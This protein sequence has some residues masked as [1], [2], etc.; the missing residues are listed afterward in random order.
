M[1]TQHP[2]D[3][4]THDAPGDDDHQEPQGNPLGEDAAGIDLEALARLL[5]GEDLETTNSST[6]ITHTPDGTSIEFSAQVGDQQD[7]DPNQVLARQMLAAAL[8]LLTNDSCG[9]RVQDERQETEQTD[10]EE[11]H[12]QGPGTSE[13]ETSESSNVQTKVPST[14]QE[15]EKT[16]SPTGKPV[17]E[18]SGHSEHK[19]FQDPPPK[20]FVPEPQHEMLEYACPNAGLRYNRSA[21]PQGG[22][23]DI[24]TPCNDCE[25]C[26]AYRNY[27]KVQQYALSLPSSVA[28]ILLARFPT[29]DDANTFATRKAHHYRL[30]GV[31]RFTVLHQSGTNGHDQPCWVRIIWDGPSTN[32]QR[33]GARSHARK[34][35]GTRVTAKVL[36]MS[37]DQFLEWLPNQFAIESSKPRKDGRGKRINT[38]RFSNGWV[39]P[40]AMPDDWLH[41]RTVNMP[42]HPIHEQRVGLRQEP[43]GYAIRQSWRQMFMRNPDDPEALRAVERARYINGVDWIRRWEILEP[44]KIQACRSYIDQYLS[45][46]RPSIKDWQERTLGPRGLVIETAKWLNQEREPEPAVVMVAARLGYVPEGTEPVIDVDY[47]SQLTSRLPDLE[48]QPAA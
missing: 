17:T 39:Q 41:G 1:A 4:G 14:N 43:R 11:H 8:R 19:T 35:G 24:P 2:I 32:E 42:A 40:A 9:L 34:S 45:G 20:R 12:D 22:D 5:Q 44:R 15:P 21:N 16:Q 23:S 10:N 7:S 33:K 30:D 13:P 3:G 31:R 37:S 26:V 6:R 25:K 36:S 47:L 48:F 46:R 18:E 28:T 38:C 29:P 27:V